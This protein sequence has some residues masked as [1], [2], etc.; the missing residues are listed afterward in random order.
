LHV[1]EQG[2]LLR[3]DDQNGGLLV[4]DQ[5]PGQSPAPGDVPLNMSTSAQPPAAPEGAPAYPPP[6]QG[7]PA[8]PPP[9]APEGASA[10][11][12]PQGAP[13]YP[14]PAAPQGAPAYPPP[15]TGQPAAYPP[16]PVY[17]PAPAAHLPAVLQGRTLASWGD[18]FLASLV[19]GLVAITIIGIFVNWFMIGREG[20]KNGM[21]LGK[22]VIGLRIVREDGSP[23]TVGT[24]ILR[25]FVIK[26]LV[27]GFVGWFLIGIPVLLDY[28]WPLWDDRNQ[29]LHDK[30]A[31]TF[32]VKA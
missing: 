13:A 27:I 28:L 30:M 22:Q 6:P 18:R 17:A 8:Y 15:P 11:P 5:Q 21:S 24:A 7:A 16:P 32:V 4:S 3:L 26:T 23:M 29:A 14:P 12:P 31:S 2:E 1:R 10:Y 20:D 9:A 25:E 19:D